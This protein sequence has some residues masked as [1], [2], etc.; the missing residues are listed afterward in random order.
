MGSGHLSGMPARVP[1]SSNM[2]PAEGCPLVAKVASTVK[3]SYLSSAPH[4]L[5][6]LGQVP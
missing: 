3:V 2:A 1:T 6:G 5:E 4:L